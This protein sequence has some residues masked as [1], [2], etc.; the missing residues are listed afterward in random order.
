MKKEVYLDNAASTPL[1]PP[2]VDAMVESLNTCYGNP[3]SIHRQGRSARTCI[4]DAR[5]RIANHLNAS[6]GEIFFT[7][8][9]TESNN[10]AIKCAVNDLGVTRIISTRI[11]HKCVLNAVKRMDALPSIVVQYVKTDRH[12]EVDY[13]HLKSLLEDDRAVTLVSLIHAHNE[14]GTIND[15]DRI[16]QLCREHRAYLHSDTVQTICH[17]P[18]D[19]QKTRIDFISASA[20]KFHGPKGIGFLYING[21]TTIQP[22]L[23]G[24]GQER[25]MR[26]GTENVAGIV[27]HGHR[28]GLLHG[29]N[30]RAKSTYPF[31]AQLHEKKIT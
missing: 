10:T 15:L 24:G 27:G 25:N 18:M 23:D 9:G 8:G 7:S 16:S 29:E 11:E 2:V 1:I 21:E 6:I 3:S 12:G 20:H 14:L 30:G 4:E 17:L 5:K 22:L 26:A 31:L 13:D 19:V 28:Y